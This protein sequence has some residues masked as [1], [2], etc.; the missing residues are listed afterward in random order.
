[1]MHGK[2]SLSQ[3]VDSF[4]LSMAR[5]TGGDPASFASERWTDVYPSV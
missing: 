3:V 4:F 2:T 1:M 5:H